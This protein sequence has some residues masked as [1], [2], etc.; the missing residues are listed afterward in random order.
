M[1]II[2]TMTTTTGVAKTIIPCIDAISRTNETLVLR[3]V[4]DDQNILT[5]KE[6]VFKLTGYI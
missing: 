2:I 4:V 3:N 6:D 1:F 5:G